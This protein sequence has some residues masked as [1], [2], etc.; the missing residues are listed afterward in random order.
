MS[1]SSIWL[2]LWAPG[3]QVPLLMFSSYF[4]ESFKSGQAV[5]ASVGKNQQKLVLL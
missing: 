3:L 2:M 1:L 4:S 5:A